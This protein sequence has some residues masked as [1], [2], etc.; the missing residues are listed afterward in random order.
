[1][2]CDNVSN[3]VLSN[4][5]SA[6]SA[7]GMLCIW[8]TATARVGL[9]MFGTRLTTKATMFVCHNIVNL[10]AETGKA[11]GIPRS[12]YWQLHQTIPVS[13]PWIYFMCL[14][15][16]FYDLN[17]AL[18]IPIEIDMYGRYISGAMW[19]CWR[20]WTRSNRPAWQTRH[21]Y[22]SQAALPAASQLTSTVALHYIVL[23]CCFMV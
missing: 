3:S 15:W 19:T 6:I 21:R 1:M 8:C 16:K 5:H 13:I 4:H 7:N 11:T 12:L 18:P 17:A 2:Y 20:W 9:A 23:L 10:Y 14:K 22:W